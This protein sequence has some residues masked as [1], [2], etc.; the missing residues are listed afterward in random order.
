MRLTSFR[1]R[2]AQK[3]LSLQTALIHR[4]APTASGR[5][6]QRPRSAPVA[7]H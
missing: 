6:R 7:R 4:F 2:A 3:R 1:L 5:S